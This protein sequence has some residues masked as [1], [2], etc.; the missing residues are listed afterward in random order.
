M[1]IRI[2]CV[3]TFSEN[4]NIISYVIWLWWTRQSA[5]FLFRENEN[6]NTTEIIDTFFERKP[7]NKKKQTLKPDWSHRLIKQDRARKRS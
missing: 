6:E 1:P 4:V 2:R 3:S 5:M 7:E